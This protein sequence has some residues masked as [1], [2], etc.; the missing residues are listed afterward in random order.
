M[1]A[2][3]AG[4]EHRDRPARSVEAGRL[5]LVRL[6]DGNAVA[7]RDR[8]EAILVDREHG[9]RPGQRGEGVG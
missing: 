4:V 2:V 5:R 3:D 7:Q 6:D 9:S 8:L 1:S